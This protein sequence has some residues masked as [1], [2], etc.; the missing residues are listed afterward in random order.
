MALPTASKAPSTRERVRVF[1]EDP[2]LASGLDAEGLAAAQQITAPMLRVPTGSWDF[3]AD[4]SRL[5]SH[6][7][8]LVVD[9]LLL[10]EVI[11]GEVACAELL[12]TGDVLRPWPT[13]TFAGRKS[14]SSPS[15]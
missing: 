11:V 15:S 13:T 3:Q 5:S 14:A 1:V 9:G 12:G 6:L 8:L 10:R 2:E 4:P 7:G